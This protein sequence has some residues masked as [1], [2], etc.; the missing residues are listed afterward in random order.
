MIRASITDNGPPRFAEVPNFTN[1]EPPG[2][3]RESVS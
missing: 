1:V 3:I 2:Q